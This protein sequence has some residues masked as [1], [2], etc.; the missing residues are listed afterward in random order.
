MSLIMETRF[1]RFSSHVMF[2]SSSLSNDL[3]LI[4]AIKLV[5]RFSF[6]LYPNFFLKLR[7]A[8]FK[9]FKMVILKE[10]LLFGL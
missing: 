1:A 8:I 2:F 3:S 9:V 10:D 7:A 6:F 4:N 5:R